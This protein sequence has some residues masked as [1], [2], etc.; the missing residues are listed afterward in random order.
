LFKAVLTKLGSA[1]RQ[2]AALRFDY[3]KIV[4]GIAGFCGQAGRPEAPPSSNFTSL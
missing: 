4:K 3:G 2:T 1:A